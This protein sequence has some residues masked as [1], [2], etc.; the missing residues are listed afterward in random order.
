MPEVV[1]ALLGRAGGAGA[2]EELPPPP[3]GRPAAAR[4]RCSSVANT[5][6]IGCRPGRSGGSKRP[7]APA[8]SSAARAAAPRGLD[9]LPGTTTSPGRPVGTD[10]RAA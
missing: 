3:A 10:T 4:G 2:A 6:P 1:L 7:P 8:A 5:G 9:G